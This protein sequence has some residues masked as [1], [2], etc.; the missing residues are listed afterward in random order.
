VVPIGPEE[1]YCFGF[2]LQDEPRDLPAEG[3]A[4]RSRFDD[5]ADQ[6]AALIDEIDPAT[7]TFNHAWAVTL[8][9]SVVGRCVLIGDAAHASSPSTAQGAAL[10][11]EDAVVLA[12]VVADDERR[13]DRYE[14]AR[15]DRVG[16]VGVTNRQRTEALKLPEAVRME[17]LQEF[18]SITE[19]TFAPLQS[20]P[21]GA[22][23]ELDARLR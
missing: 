19:R 16:Y 15:V 3:E 21:R 6:G 7:L 5:F 11:F 10:A 23:P 12:A 1:T 13:L 20:D 14:R 18:H 9:T 4:M 2:V 8:P 22:I 17:V